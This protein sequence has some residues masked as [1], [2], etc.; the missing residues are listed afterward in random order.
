MKKK[1]FLAALLGAAFIGGFAGFD[2]CVAHASSLSYADIA[3]AAGNIL[4]ETTT[5]ASDSAVVTSVATASESTGLSGAKTVTL[6]ET[7]HADYGLYEESINGLFFFY[8]T[9]AN[10]SILSEPVSLEIPANLTCVFEKDGVGYTYVVGQSISQIG[11]YVITITGTADGVTYQAVYRFRIQ[12]ASTLLTDTTQSDTSSTTALGESTESAVQEAADT[13]ATDATEED[14]E[15]EA[16]AAELISDEGIVDEEALEEYLA[17]VIGADEARVN[18]DYYAESTGLS[19]YYDATTGYYIHEL[20]SGAIFYTTVANGTL[21][22]DGV[23]IVSND[24]ITF[25][26]LKDGEE[27]AYSLGSTITEAGSYTVYATQSGTLFISAYYGKSDPVFHFRIIDGD[28]KDLGILN[29]PQGA[30]ICT[31][32]LDGTDVFSQ[33]SADG[34]YAVLDTDG[35][36][37]AEFSDAK[38]VSALTVTVDTTKPRVSAAKSGN[39]MYFTYLSDDVAQCLL[40]KS[41]SLYGSAVQ[42]ASVS[43]AGSYVIEIYDAAGNMTST[44]FTIDYR[45]DVIGVIAIVVLAALLIALFAFVYRLRRKVDIR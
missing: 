44:S 12:D 3:A 32:T 36:Y 18:T 15:E 5:A 35:T 23:R 41:G 24:D 20:L 2:V 8:T 43:T 4:L 19:S 39:T 31:L 26:V 10:G 33:V 42:I 30:T 28:V 25:T 6:T 27:M 21:T 1:V 38:G 40:Y 22:N 7:Y 45:V 37:Y 9:A 17:S 29:A 34:S 11:S 14:A 16:L 13:E